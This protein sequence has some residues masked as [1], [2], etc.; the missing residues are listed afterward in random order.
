MLER[1][2]DISHYC[3]LDGYARYFQIHI[4]PEHQPKTIFIC[5][6]RTF[7]NQRMPF[8]LCNALGTFQQCM[9][10]IFL[11]LLEH[12]ME[13]FMDDFTVYDFSFDV[14]LDSL[15]QVMHQD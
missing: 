5:P 13:I 12:C 10:S 15:S 7:I 1:L 8:G 3:F 9:V 11:D 2:A 4:T 6:F 14:C